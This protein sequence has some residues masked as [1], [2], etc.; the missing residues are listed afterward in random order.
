MPNETVLR[1]DQTR[2]C[3]RRMPPPHDKSTRRRSYDPGLIDVAA[4]QA[5]ARMNHSQ[6][7]VGKHG[8]QVTLFFHA[9]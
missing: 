3:K 5:T 9:I 7:I 4:I 2:L 8:L 1:F 6:I